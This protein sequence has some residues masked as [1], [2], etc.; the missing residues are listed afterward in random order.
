S[1]LT[2]GMDAGFKT[3]RKVTRNGVRQVGRGLEKL[4]DFMIDVAKPISRIP[5]IGKPMAA[6]LTWM[7]SGIRGFGTHLQAVAPKIAD[8]V[9]RVGRNL[10]TGVQAAWGAITGQ[11][12]PAFTN[13]MGTIGDLLGPIKDIGSGFLDLFK[14]DIVQGLKNIGGGFK[15]LGSGILDVGTAWTGFVS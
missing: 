5:I 14:G 3:L 11:L 10:V 15:D 9:E 13:L 12:G 7:G 1:F 2:G 8:F 6:A 4:G